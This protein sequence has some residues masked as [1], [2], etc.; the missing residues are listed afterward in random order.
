MAVA[1][2]LAMPLI[3]I[4]SPPA[5]AACSNAVDPAAKMADADAVFVGRVTEVS[6][7]GRLATMEVLEIW[8]GPELP[9]EVVVNGSFSGSDQIGASDRTFIAGN[10]YVVV[11]LG[12]RSP[13]FD[14]A[15]SGTHLY[16][17]TGTIPARFQKAVGVDAPRMP[18]AP[19]SGAAASDDGSAGVN[20]P[21]LAGAAA[22]ALLIM[23]MVARRRK[24]RAAVLDRDSTPAPPA[25]SPAEPTDGDRPAKRAKQP[26]PEP[27][28]AAA[29]TAVAAVAG[30]TRKRFRPLRAI[31][32]A[33]SGIF[34]KLRRSR[35]GLQ[36]LEAIRKKTRKIKEKQSTG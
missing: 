7:F 14:E 6:D 30:R 4:S 19:A 16:V 23:W 35:S 25:Q 22:G 1:L 5:R 32:R 17:P 31:G 27:A 2:M 34:S 15:C 12:S 29:A 21:L 26:Q 36:S 18:A 13:F 28:P 20:L 11:P 9:P 33:L 24:R 8:K 10:T 3:L